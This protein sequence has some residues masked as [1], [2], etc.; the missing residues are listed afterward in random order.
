MTFAGPPPAQY[1]QQVVGF[2]SQF[3]AV[4][5]MV[6]AY[7]GALIFVA[8]LAEMRHPWDF[9]K[10]LLMAQ[11]FICVVYVFFGAYVSSTPLCAV[12]GEGVPN[13]GNI[14]STPNG[15]NTLAATF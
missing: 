11:T 14:R 13:C 8:F 15:D 7:S 1:Q 12:Q 4:N 3:G 2:A 5:V 10:G 6:Y 9:W